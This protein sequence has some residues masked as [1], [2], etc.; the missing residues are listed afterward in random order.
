M[1]HRSPPDNSFSQVNSANQSQNL[2]E[3]VDPTLSGTIEAGLLVQLFSWSKGLV[4]RWLGWLIDQ[5]PSQIIRSER[6]ATVDL[7]YDHYQLEAMIAA[8]TRQLEQTQAEHYRQLYH[9]AAF[10]RLASG[11]FHDIANP[12]TAVSLSL[13][14]MQE[15]KPSEDLIRAIEATRRMQRS[16][17]AARR[18][19][20][21]QEQRQLFSVNQEIEESL[22][23]LKYKLIKRH[24]AI[25][26]AAEVGIT[27]FGNAL[28]FQ[29]IITNIISNAID[30]YD[31]SE[32][33][34]K[35]RRIVLKLQ[36]I[37]KTI[38]V[39]V[40]DWGIGI[41]PTE[42]DKIF[43]PFFTTKNTDRGTGIGL[44]FAKEML[45]LDFNGR[46]SVLSR[47]NR[48]TTFLLQLPI[49]TLPRSQAKPLSLI[50]RQLNQ[51]K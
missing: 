44:S 39:T 15:Q 8:R 45:E 38:E 10:G 46:I 5:S 33:P 34:I 32:R 1:Q 2:T 11:V 21:Q 16:I 22:A 29:Q 28:K 18:Q 31:Q 14:E 7:A 47:V 41:A 19:I 37:N 42:Q 27:T 49:Q 17:E 35:E 23:I 30:A 25:E 4:I 26:Y 36:T 50:S 43:E 13:E 40:K 24:V 20:Q 6:P 48:G 51:I 9:F 3:A 12:L